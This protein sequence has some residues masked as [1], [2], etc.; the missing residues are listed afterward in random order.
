[1]KKIT[2]KE[3]TLQ[4]RPNFRGCK[5]LDDVHDKIRKEHPTWFIYRGVLHI[6][7]HETSALDSPRLLLITEE[8]S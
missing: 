4:P 1:M 2:I 3:C 6:S 8:E 7:V 5:S